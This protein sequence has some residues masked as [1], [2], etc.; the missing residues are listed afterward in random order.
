MRKNNKPGQGGFVFSTDPDY[1][2]NDAFWHKRGY[3]RRPG[4]TMWLD[5]DEAGIGQTGAVEVRHPLTFWLR[6]WEAVA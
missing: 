6:D 1:R 4:M 5:W 3:V 2:P